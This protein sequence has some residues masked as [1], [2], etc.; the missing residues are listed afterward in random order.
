MFMSLCVEKSQV[1]NTSFVYEPQNTL[2]HLGS[3][4]ETFLV[5]IATGTGT[6]SYTWFKDGNNISDS[7][8]ELHIAANG[9]ILYITEITADTQGEYTCVVESETGEVINSSATFGV[10]GKS[11]VVAFDDLLNGRCLLIVLHDVTVKQ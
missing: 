11:Q 3:S 8:G 4:N 7:N 10:L 1:M 2:A 6:L 9:H 5:C